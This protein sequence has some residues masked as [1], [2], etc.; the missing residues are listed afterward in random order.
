MTV[1]AA[2]FVAL[3]VLLAPQLQKW[4]AQR[5]EIAALRNEV[6]RSQRDVA[7]LQAQSQRWKDPEYL[8]AQAR[9]RLHYVLPGEKGLVVV[10][11]AP[12]T[13]TSDPGRQAAAV[14]EPGR[15]WFGDVW[16]SVKVAGAAPPALP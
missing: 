1:L 16:E 4:F 14:A 7:A 12:G 10:G 15:P 8:K 11:A 9:E 6:A 3:T 13:A 2:L 5:A